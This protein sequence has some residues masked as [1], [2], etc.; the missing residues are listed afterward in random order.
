M[1]DYGSSIQ[2]RPEAR[3]VPRWA[4]QAVH[5][6]YKSSQFDSFPTSKAVTRRKTRPDPFFFSMRNP[7]WPTGV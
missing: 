2:T 7:K 4:R 3:Q 1:L 6:C 5:L